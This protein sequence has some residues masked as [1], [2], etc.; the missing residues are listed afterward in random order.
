MIYFKKSMGFGTY[1]LSIAR[2]VTSDFS[3]GFS[4]EAVR[5]DEILHTT[6]NLPSPL[7]LN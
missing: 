7:T 3:Q 4:Y 1:R 6:T 5:N 2:Y